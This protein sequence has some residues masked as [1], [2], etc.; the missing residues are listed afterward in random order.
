MS[1]YKGT[2]FAMQH[3]R[4]NRE[5]L[6]KSLYDRLMREMR[7]KRDQ[8]LR[9]QPDRL[10]ER[11]QLNRRIQEIAVDGRIGFYS[12]SMD[13]DGASSDYISDR[14][15]SVRLIQLHVDYLRYEAEGPVRWD[16][17]DPALAQAGP[18]SQRDYG[19]EA[20]EDGH[21]HVIYY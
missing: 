20:F 3:L 14:P 8:Q 12:W 17:T 7:E 2:V 1:D 11:E 21:P 15:A 4:Q 10:A 6:N 9:Q 19:S 5:K 16:L 18:L 13:C